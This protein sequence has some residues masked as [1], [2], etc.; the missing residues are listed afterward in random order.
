MKLREVMN[1]HILTLSPTMDVKDAM[2]S[3]VKRSN[4]DTL[5]DILYVVENN[6]L[7]GA[8]DLKDLIIA[9]SPILVVKYHA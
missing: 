1:T 5:I 9:R 6:I 7:L 8:V 2:K 4:D 3:V